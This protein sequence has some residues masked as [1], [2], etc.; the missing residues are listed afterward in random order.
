[1][2]WQTFSVTMVVL[3]VE[4]VVRAV[5]CFFLK[6]AI[7]GQNCSRQLHSCLKHQKT[8]A[9]QCFRLLLFSEFALANFGVKRRAGQCWSGPGGGC[10][11]LRMGSTNLLNSF[12]LG[13]V[14]AA[15]ALSAWQSVAVSK[16]GS[17][18]V[19]KATSCPFSHLGE[20][21]KSEY[22]DPLLKQPASHA[23]VMGAVETREKPKH[24]LLDFP[25]LQHGLGID[26]NK[27]LATSIV[28]LDVF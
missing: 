9:T 28:N 3:G 20:Y 21:P 2:V 15:L 13:T 25:T 24:G 18:S 4:L 17:A 8:N 19:G 11:M 26:L 7:W 14:S 27:S 22:G 16:C 5:K 1:M 12:F 10:W 23:E 6:F